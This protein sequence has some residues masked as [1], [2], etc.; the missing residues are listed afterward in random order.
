M[1]VRTLAVHL[2]NSLLSEGVLSPTHED[3][4]QPFKLI[5]AEAFRENVS[6]LEVSVDLFDLHIV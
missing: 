2:L 4:T 5:G 1:L 6:E 3:F